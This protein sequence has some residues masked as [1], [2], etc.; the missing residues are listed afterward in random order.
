MKKKHQEVF[1]PLRAEVVIINS[2]IVRQSA[3]NRV[4]GLINNLQKRKNPPKIILT[5]CL[6]GWA[7]RNPQNLRLL[8]KRIGKK[9]KIIP[10]EKLASFKVSP[11][12]EKKTSALV[13]ISNGC[14]HFCTYCI[15]PYARGTEK[16]RPAREIIKE[17]ECLVKNGYQEITLLGQNVNSYFDAQKKIDFPQLLEIIAGIKG[18]K[19]INFLSPNPADFSEKLIAVIQKNP[20]I[21]RTIHLPL[22]SGDD[23]ILKKMNRGYTAHQYL[24]LVKKIKKAVPEVEFTTDIIVGFPGETKKQFQNTVDLCRKVG[25][26]KAF[27]ARYSPRPGTVAAQMED[28]V[29]PQEKKR[30]WQVLDQLINQK[31]Q[32]EK[33]PAEE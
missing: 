7:K 23:E 8:R 25:F 2:C 17:I 33:S 21:S 26:K 9:V 27:I 4:Y 6:A 10:T 24:T 16:D 11:Q 12:R 15:V 28:N 18:V 30:R 22:Q 20:L 14:N 31:S 1:S 29:S 5:G 3:E 13:P 19:K 32:E